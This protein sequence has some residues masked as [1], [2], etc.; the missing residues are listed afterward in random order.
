MKPIFLLDND[1]LVYYSLIIKLYDKM[2]PLRTIGD[3]P[4]LARPAVSHS[5]PFELKKR[6]IP[7]RSGGLEFYLV[8]YIC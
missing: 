5:T 3:K 2:K 6:L 4:T 7:V 1:Y 8:C